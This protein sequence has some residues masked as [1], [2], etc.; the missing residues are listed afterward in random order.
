MSGSCDAVLNDLAEH[1][2]VEYI[3]ELEQARAYYQ[4]QLSEECR[5]HRQLR[6]AFDAQARRIE[7]YGGY[8]PS[9]APWPCVAC[10][11]SCCRSPD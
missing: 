8:V 11:Q 1:P 5:K 9:A 3:R 4:K 2:T 7:R 6:V 10:Q